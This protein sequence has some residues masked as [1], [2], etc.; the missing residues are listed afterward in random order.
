MIAKAAMHSIFPIYAIELIVSF[1]AI[2]VLTQVL[3]A[4]GISL[5]AAWEKHKRSQPQVRTMERPASAVQKNS[6][7]VPGRPEHGACH[8]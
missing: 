5:V 2:V 4:A 3:I 8:L 1:I 7:L 6:W